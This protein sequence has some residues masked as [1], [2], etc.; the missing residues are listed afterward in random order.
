MTLLDAINNAYKEG[1][2]TIYKSEFP[3]V[4][5]C[6]TDLSMPL[7]IPDQEYIEKNGHPAFWNP[8]PDDITDADWD[9]VRSEPVRS[10]ERFVKKRIINRPKEY[11][12]IIEYFEEGSKD[13]L[14]E[15][16]RQGKPFGL[17]IISQ[18]VIWYDDNAKFT[19]VVS[20]ASFEDAVRF[21]DQQITECMVK[22]TKESWLY[23][24][25]E[26]VVHDESEED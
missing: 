8:T 17:D 19:L 6:F 15:V 16:I 14:E 12:I 25:H 7:Y 1:T 22:R 9:Y 26:G 4:K 24:D 11:Y 21:Y 20:R 18:D 23:V 5:L 2:K 13:V 3:D 10:N